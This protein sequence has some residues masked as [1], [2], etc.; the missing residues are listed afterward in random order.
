MILKFAFLSIQHGEV[1]PYSV[2]YDSLVKN[3]LGDAP[4][5]T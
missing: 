2:E 1:I 4:S 5:E 3:I